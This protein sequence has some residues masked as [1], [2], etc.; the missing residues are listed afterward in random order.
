MATLWGLYFLER[1]HKFHPSRGFLIAVSLL[2]A[3][4]FSSYVLYCFGKRKVFN[5][6]APFQG[7]WIQRD[8]EPVLYW[9]YMAL[10]S[11]WGGVGIYAS[12]MLITKGSF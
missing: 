6:L 8:E 12:F 1:Y 11:F 5:G 7:V 4:S 3:I 9:F 10:F 2:L